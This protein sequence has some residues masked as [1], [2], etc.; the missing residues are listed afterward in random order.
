[1]RNLLIILFGF[2]FGFILLAA[3]PPTKKSNETPH[4]VVTDVL[5]ARQSP[6]DMAFL[7]DMT[8]FFTEKC[9]GLSVLHPDGSID[10]LFGTSGSALEATDLFCVGQSGMNG[11]TLDPDFAN[12]RF[13]YV[14]M[15]SNLSTNP[16][17]NRVIRLVVANDNKAV[18][19]RV[20]I[21]T[22][23]AF[24]DQPNAWGEAG[25]HSGGR[26]RF[27]PDG[28]LYITTGDN[29]NGTLPQDPARLGG[30]ILRVDRDGVAAPDNAFPAGGDIRIFAYGLRN[31]QGITFKPGSGRAMIAEHGPN[32]S[33]EVTALTNGGNG[34]WDPKPDP[35]VVCADDYCGYISN[36]ASGELTPMTDDTKFPDAMKPLW[37]LQDSQ[38]MG[39]AT[40][41]TG[42]QWK[43]W[44][45]ALLIG[46]MAEMK[47][48]AL[49][50]NANDEL[51][52]TTPMALPAVRYR[53]LVQGPDGN[54][55][56]ATD[57]GQI[58]KV[59]PQ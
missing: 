18:S 25:S 11:V 44:D 20:D 10:R 6:W 45:G 12:N 47:V 41:I 26:L 51:I 36:K 55:Y 37:I 54:L 27:G 8:M 50:L 33:D 30:K 24:K 3:A 42:A 34:G 7:P 22:D 21:V 2:A 29:H 31:P 4:L 58:L 46:V 28:Y 49:N 15:S 52:G 23:I 56:V 40:F 57:E 38:G 5:T 17:T 13:I 59:T 35:G 14:F 48:H 9:E 43:T 32:H 1:M 53:S 16:R 19:D 39:P